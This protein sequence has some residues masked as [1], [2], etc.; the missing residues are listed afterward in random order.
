MVD[1]GLFSMVIVLAVFRCGSILC[2]LLG[3]EDYFGSLGSGE[4]HL[5]EALVVLCDNDFSSAVGFP[6]TQTLSLGVWYQYD[7]DHVGTATLLLVSSASDR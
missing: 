7:N 4:R 6:F 5:N 1:V 2:F 3:L